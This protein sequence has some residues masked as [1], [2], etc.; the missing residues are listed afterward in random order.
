MCCV[1]DGSV[2]TD[3]RTYTDIFWDDGG[4]P[5][6]SQSAALDSTVESLRA[7]LHAHCYRMLGSVHDAD[8]ALQETMVRAWKGLGGLADPGA[9]R[10]WLY[11]I[12]TN[13]CL[14]MLSHRSRRELPTDLGPGSPA[15]EVAWLG[16]YPEHRPGPEAEAI[17]RESVEVAFVAA[18]HHLPAR[19]R[20]VLLLREVLG[21]SAREVAAQL[22]TTAASVNSALQRARAALDERSPRATQRATLHALGD[23]A[24][25]ALARRYADAWHAGDVDAIVAML[26][27][28]A[29]YSMP[30]LP[31]WYAGRVDIGGFLAE[32]VP[33]GWRFLPTRANGQLAFGTYRWDAGKYVPGGLDVL[34]LRGAE[35]VEVVSFLDADLTMF[36]LPDE[37]PARTGS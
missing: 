31:R 28:D 26:A 18:I 36:G 17:A 12:A 11:R 4:M 35:V 3:G 5:D 29:R 20:A 24:V 1:V 9:V 33:W 32:A 14:T 21:F 25:R 16:P 10:P 8:D 30:P 37:L 6:P 13:R 22:D 34:S 23:D 27:E 2:P 19:Q 15:A 7:E